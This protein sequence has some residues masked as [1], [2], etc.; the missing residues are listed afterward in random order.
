MTI[1]PT[2]TWILVA[3]EDKAKILLNEGR[4]SG[5][6]PIFMEQIKFE[7]DGPANGEKKARSDSWFI[8]LFSPRPK[9]MTRV[10]KAKTVEAL[11]NDVVQVINRAAKRQSFDCLVLVGPKSAI[12]NISGDLG[13]AAQERLHGQLSKDLSGA[14]EFELQQQLKYIV[15][16]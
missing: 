10:K 16:L 7:L 6:T 12:S 1:N 3:S 5:L 9:K 13:P 8:N 14:D 2:I 4:G 15:R 11:I